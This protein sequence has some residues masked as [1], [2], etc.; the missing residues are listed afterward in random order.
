MITATF[1]AI[2]MI[3][4]FFVKVRAVFSGEKEDADEALRLAHEHM[5]RDDKP[6]HGDDAGKKD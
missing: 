6:E 1:L 3:P 5:H 4:M 2:F